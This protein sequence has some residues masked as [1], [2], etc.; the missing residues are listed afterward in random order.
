MIFLR[1]LAYVIWLYGSMTAIGLAAAPF[2]AF[3]QRAA[4][5][6]SR[7]WGKAAIWGVRIICGVRL[8]VRGREHIPP[9]AGLVAAKHQSMLD[10]I[11]PFCL[12]WNPAIVLKRELLAMPMFGWFCQRLGMIAIDREAHASAL[13]DMLRTARAR[14]AAGRAIVIFPEGTRQEPGAAPDYKPGVAALYRDLKLPCTP[15]ALNTGLTWSARGIIR[16]PG[17]AVIEFLPAIPAGLSRE[18]FMRELEARIES[19]SNRL[20]EEGR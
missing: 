14:S 19:A 13:R 11:A 12:M 17:R 8:E 9:G 6:A 1:S 3:S 16:R 4:I 7:L 10:T 15:V 18:D 20:I 5:A 2:A